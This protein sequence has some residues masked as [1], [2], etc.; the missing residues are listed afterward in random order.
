MIA[1]MPK[2]SFIIPVYNQERY[3]A[4]AVESALT[5]TLYDLEVLAIDDSS[6]DGSLAILRA[7]A[8]QRLRI[9]RTPTNLG[10]GGAR[11]LGLDVARGTYLAFLDSD[12]LAE[13]DRAARQMAHLEAHPEQVVVGSSYTVIDE[14]GGPLGVERPVA[15][16]P[17][18]VRWNALF[19]AS[20]HLTTCLVR[21][22]AVRRHGLRFSESLRITEDVRFLSALLLAGEGENLPQPLTRYRRHP[23]MTSRLFETQGWSAFD[24]VTQDNIQALGVACDTALAV[25]LRDWHIAQLTGTATPRDA[26]EELVAKLYATLKTIFTERYGVPP[27][28]G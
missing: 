6:T 4:Q 9:L 21:A 27:Q 17:A 25:R 13:P 12:D 22:E 18:E 1:P 20:F 3:V 8:D 28:A 19:M 26:M 24:Q 2:V 7:I 11:N 15:V 10:P 14:S 16:T 23:G 5:Q